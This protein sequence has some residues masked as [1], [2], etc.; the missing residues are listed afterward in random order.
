MM[1]LGIISQIKDPMS[2]E[3]GLS[4]SFLGNDYN[5]I[6]FLDGIS[7]LG[8]LAGFMS[9]WTFPLKKPVIG[10]F[11]ISILLII[12]ME[13]L[14]ISKVADTFRYLLLTC[15]RLLLGF[16]RVYSFVPYVILKWPISNP[17]LVCNRN[18]RRYLRNLN[19]LTSDKHPKTWLID[20]HDD[21]P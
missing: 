18:G 11:F 20:C 14:I 3:F 19:S 10:T 5:K 15:S 16:F 13:S 1:T 21:I 9:M 12:S 7:F 8:G 2:K 17:N 6:G 4:E